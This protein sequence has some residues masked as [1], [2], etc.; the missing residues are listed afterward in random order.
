[1]RHVRRGGRYLRVAKPSWSDPLSGAYSRDVG[2][3]WNRPGAFAVIYLNATAAVAR[4]QVRQQLG[5][6]GIEPEDL[7][8]RSG[9]MLVATDVPDAVFVD[10][11]T[12]K[13]LASLGLPTSYPLDATGTVV[14]HAACQPLGAK[15]HDTKEPGIAARSAAAV[16]S[17]G[18]ELAYFASR[19]LKEK[20]RLPFANWFWDRSPFG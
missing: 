16:P 8:P 7:D 2:G 3:R 18:E 6:L 1:M 9:P 12:D 15:A 14:G 20:G 17:P 10:A 5:P 4:A 11:V 13:G 19:R